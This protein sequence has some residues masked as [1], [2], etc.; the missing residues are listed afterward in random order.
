M[1]SS[2]DYASRPSC[3]EVAEKVK[4][5]VC[6]GE[7]CAI[8]VPE[9]VAG[10][11]QETGNPHNNKELP[12]KLDCGG[13]GNRIANLNSNKE[14][15][16]C[17]TTETLPEQK[18]TQDTIHTEDGPGSPTLSVTEPVQN[19]DKAG[20]QKC[21]ICVPRDS[22][23]SDLPSSVI[24]GLRNWHELPPHIRT[25]VVALLRGAMESE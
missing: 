16:E 7:E 3:P 12:A 6:P 14:L 13:G 8:C 5:A 19:H 15:Q 11:E 20:H 10:A 9:K 1:A 17:Y 25:A 2:T 22:L 21:A 18:R 24:S 4:Q 23:P